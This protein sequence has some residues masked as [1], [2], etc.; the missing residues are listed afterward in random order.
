MPD[1]I[2]PGAERASGIAFLPDDI[3]SAR[4]VWMKGHRAMAR[5]ILEDSRVKDAP[6]R[7]AIQEHYDFTEAWIRDWEADHAG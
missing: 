3:G 6:A 5:R 1:S 4:L 2:R 7:A